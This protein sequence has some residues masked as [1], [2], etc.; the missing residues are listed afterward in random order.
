MTRHRYLFVFILILCI[1]GWGC[2]SHGGDARHRISGRDQQTYIQADVEA[3]IRF[4]RD[5]AARIL[6]N[7]DLWDNPRATRYLNLVGR[8]L[9]LYAGRSELEFSFGILDSDEVNAFAAPGG[10]ILV[11]RGALLRMTDESQLAAVLGHEI[12][13]VLQRHMV[14][15]LKLKAEQGSATGALAGLIGGAAGGVRT[16]LESSL[17]QA[18]TILLNRGYKIEDE[19]EADRIGLLIASAAGYD[20][21]ALKV[22]LQ[23]VK[24]FEPA[25]HGLRKSHPA[26]AERL[27]S[28]DQAVA[29]NGL[30]GTANPKFKERFHEMVRN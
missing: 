10:Y 20:P 14:K 25:S 29:A 2:S 16:A 9:C 8:A 26:L 30:V 24:Q 3:E 4:G 22:F 17:N 27:L 11:T 6:A 1:Q 18:V 13:H 12:A 7:Y 23:S 5:L 19:L 28:I 21:L 15:E